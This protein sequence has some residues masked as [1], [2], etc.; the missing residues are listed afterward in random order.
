MWKWFFVYSV[1]L[2]ETL[3]GIYFGSTN[4][5]NS[6]K[7]ISTKNNNKISIHSHLLHQLQIQQNVY[8]EESIFISNSYSLLE[9]E[10]KKISELPSSLF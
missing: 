5:N 3:S 9:K 6:C 1:G 2:T 4:N 7:K 10:R 8:E